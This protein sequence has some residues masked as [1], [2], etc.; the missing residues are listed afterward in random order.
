MLVQVKSNFNLGKKW[1]W[2]FPVFLHSLVV[3][4]KMLTLSLPFL[5]LRLLVSCFRLNT[6]EP[7]SYCPQNSPP[8]PISFLFLIFDKISSH[9]G[10]WLISKREMSANSYSSIRLIRMI[11]QLIIFY[12]ANLVKNHTNSSFLIYSNTFISPFN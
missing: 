10:K 3:S 4:N 11:P 1:C 7:L 6:F 8:N 2:I 5:K 12:Y 9:F